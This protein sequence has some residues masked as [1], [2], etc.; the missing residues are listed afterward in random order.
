MR[1]V[2][3]IVGKRK[4]V[5]NHVLELLQRADF[6]DVAGRLGL[7][8]CL[9]ACERI[10]TFARRSRRLVLNHDLT[11]SGQRKALWA[12]LAHC[13]SDFVVESIE[14]CADVFFRQSGA[15]RNIGVNFGLGRRFFSSSRRHVREPSLVLMGS[16]EYLET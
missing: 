14:D 12:L 8:H 6:H 2:A 5:L 10:D 9:F 15:L 11:Q 3:K 13:P 16:Q 1:T 7:E 4:R